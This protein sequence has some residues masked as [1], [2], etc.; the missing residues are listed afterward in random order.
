MDFL[1]TDLIVIIFLYCDTQTLFTI[2]KT[3]KTIRNIC[4]SNIL[5]TLLGKRD[6]PLLE[7][8]SRSDYIYKNPM[9]VHKA[10]ILDYI[11][12]NTWATNWL[13]KKKKNQNGVD[14]HRYKAYVFSIVE[15]MIRVEKWKQIK[16]YYGQSQTDDWKI[17]V[18][19]LIN[20]LLE[21]SEN[22]NKE[23]YSF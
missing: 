16:K 11:R 13:L 10:H 19:I 17:G 14:E 7:I 15:C 20:E 8:H 4:N 3:N 22:E 23:L 5:W 21:N 1:I 12:G 9:F 6:H 2:S 18:N